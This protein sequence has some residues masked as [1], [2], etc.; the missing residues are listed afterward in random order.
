MCYFIGSLVEHR[1]LKPPRVISE[2]QKEQQSIIYYTHCLMLLRFRK[3]CVQLQIMHFYCCILFHLR[4][5]LQFIYAFCIFWAFQ[6]FLVLG[7]HA[8]RFS[9]AYRSVNICMCFCWIYT[10]KWAWSHRHTFIC[11]AA[12]YC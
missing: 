10:Q 4:H 1:Q 3:R 6:K 12:V 7:H 5:E 8:Q 2:V 9:A 11:S